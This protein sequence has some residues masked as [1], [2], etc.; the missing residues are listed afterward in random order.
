[1]EIRKDVMGKLPKIGD[2]IA[3]IPPKYKNGQVY[4]GK[5]VSFTKS[6]L[7]EVMPTEHIGQTNNS[8]G[9]SPKNGF[10]LV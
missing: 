5:I 9:Y 6:G 10:V 3:F 1:M 7:P 4:V 2:T 8:G